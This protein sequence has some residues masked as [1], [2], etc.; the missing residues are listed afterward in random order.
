MPGKPHVGPRTMLLLDSIVLLGL[1]VA[2]GIDLCRLY[3]IVLQ[4]EGWPN[5]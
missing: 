5:D 3:A 4:N 2:V 1:G